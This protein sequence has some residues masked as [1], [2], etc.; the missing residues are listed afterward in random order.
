[1]ILTISHTFVWVY[2]RVHRVLGSSGASPATSYAM[3]ELK[4]ALPQ[5]LKALRSAKQREEDGDGPWIVNL[6]E[7]GNWRWIMFFFYQWPMDVFFN[8]ENN[9]KH[10]T[11]TI[12]KENMQLKPM[13]LEARV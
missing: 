6:L 4:A 3:A 2:P 7:V 11:V 9:I 8:R 1:M 5:M 10:R 13:D 12:K